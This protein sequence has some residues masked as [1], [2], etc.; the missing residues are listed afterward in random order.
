MSFSIFFSFLFVVVVGGVFNDAF[1]TF[2]EKSI[3]S[4]KPLGFFL[5]T[6]CQKSI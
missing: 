5:V 4:N 1:N 3:V 2:G 6:E